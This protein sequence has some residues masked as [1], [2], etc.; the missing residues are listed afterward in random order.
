MPFQRKNTACVRNQRPQH[1]ESKGRKSLP[2]S[3]LP[4]PRQTSSL[5][6]PASTSSVMPFLF[7]GKFETQSI[8]DRLIL[9]ICCLFKT[10]H[11]KI[12]IQCLLGGVREKPIF[13][14]IILKKRFYY[15]HCVKQSQHS[16]KKELSF[17]CDSCSHSIF[18]CNL[19]N[20]TTWETYQ[21]I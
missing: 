13:F 8:P 16:G 12:F 2:F 20:Q 21:R 3:S 10:L 1:G 14:I 19:L 11:L 18:F 4:P 6:V 7:Q 15:S 5:E 9:I 17:L